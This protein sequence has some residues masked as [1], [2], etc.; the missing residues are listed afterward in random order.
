MKATERVKMKNLATNFLIQTSGLF[1][2]VTCLLIKVHSDTFNFC[3]TFYVDNFHVLLKKED[4]KMI[5]LKGS[6]VAPGN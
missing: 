3:L 2:R 1:L 6:S 4:D 5:R